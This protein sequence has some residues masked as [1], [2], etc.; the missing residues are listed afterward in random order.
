MYRSIGRI[1]TYSNYSKFESAEIPQFQ[2]SIFCELCVHLFQRFLIKN[3]I[4]ASLFII[5]RF[6][7]W[8]FDLLDEKKDSHYKIFKN[9]N[10]NNYNL[11]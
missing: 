4:R 3:S 8:N 2:T 6:E 5:Q 1:F 10:N 7:S 9:N 11:F